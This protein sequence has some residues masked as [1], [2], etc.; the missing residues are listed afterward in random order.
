MDKFNP[1]V[2]Y[3]GGTTT[4]DI[5]DE[6]CRDWL[7][8]RNCNDNLVGGSCEADRE[9][10]R[11][12]AFTM[13]IDHSD[14]SNSMCGFTNGECDADTCDIDLKY[15][16]AIRDYMDNFPAHQANMVTGP[17]TCTPA[18][19]DKRERKCMGDAPDVYPKRMSDLEQLLTRA[20]WN[21]DNIEDSI[22]Y[23]EGGRKLNDA[24]EKITFNVE[25]Q[26]IVFGW[27]NVKSVTFETIDDYNPYYVGWV[28]KSDIVNF[29]FQETLG[30]N[31]KGG[32][33]TVGVFS[34]SGILRQLDG[35]QKNPDSPTDFFNA[36]DTCTMTKE[37]N[38]A[39]SFYINGVLVQTAD[40]SGWNNI[41]P[42]V[43][44][45]ERL[46]FKITNV[47]YD[48]SAPHTTPAP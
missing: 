35:F 8:C 32:A 21:N 30:D 31:T 44:T 26:V 23:E 48:D 46:A 27:D 11:S 1:F 18:F 43:D 17:G 33:Q 5:L 24:K 6:I 19:K 37:D 34:G 28:E 3:L 39:L 41:Y 38:G 45:T 4:V 29:S 12:G 13:I 22:I 40:A 9:T 16:K 25:Q 15:L 42:A 2:P 14:Y 7:R 20:N 36:G 10:Q 47:E